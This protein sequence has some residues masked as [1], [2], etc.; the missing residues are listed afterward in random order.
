M[1]QK[2]SGDYVINKDPRLYRFA[3]HFQKRSA[4]D[5]TI[6]RIYIGLLGVWRLDSGP[7]KSTTV[8]SLLYNQDSMERPCFFSWLM[9]ETYF[10]P[11][12]IGSMSGI[13]TYI[14]HKNQPNV[15]KYTIHGSLGYFK[16][17]LTSNPG[18]CR[19]IWSIFYRYCRCCLRSLRGGACSSKTKTPGEDTQSLTNGSLKTMLSKRDLLKIR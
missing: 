15:G 10:E 12:P 19:E 8:G 5:G 4:T 7:N 16:G 2:L 17:Y 13:L 3:T 11:Y 1:L 18:L 9:W 14:Y 6:R